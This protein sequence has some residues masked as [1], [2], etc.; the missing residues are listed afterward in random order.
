MFFKLEPSKGTSLEGAKTF[1]FWRSSR[2]DGGAIGASSLGRTTK[3]K[4][5]FSTTVFVAGVEQAHIGMYLSGDREASHRAEQLCEIQQV[6]ESL[7]TTP[8]ASHENGLVEAMHAATNPENLFGYAWL[9]SVFTGKAKSGSTDEPNGGSPDAPEVEQRKAEVHKEMLD[10]Q[11]RLT[12][13]SG[14]EP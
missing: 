9:H 3:K 4:S 10:V 5:L 6:N 8:S 2:K 12:A 11:E 13:L 1:T 14:S 7:L